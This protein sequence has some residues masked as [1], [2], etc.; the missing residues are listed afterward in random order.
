MEASAPLANEANSDA[1]DIDEKLQNVPVT[2]KSVLNVREQANLLKAFKSMRDIAVKRTFP[3]PFNGCEFSFDLSHPENASTHIARQHVS[4]KCIWCDE[5]HFEWWNEAQRQRHLRYKHR[6]K[7]LQTLGV[8]DPKIL[9]SSSDET[10]VI[11]L[12]QHECLAGEV[13]PDFGTDAPAPCRVEIFCDS[14]GRDNRNFTSIYEKEYHERTCQGQILGTKGQTFCADCGD[15]NVDGQQGQNRVCGHDPNRAIGQFCILCGID[16]S[17][18]GQFADLHRSSCRGHGSATRPFA[19]CCGRRLCSDD[20]TSDRQALIGA[21]RGNCNPT[22]KIEVVAKSQGQTPLTGTVPSPIAPSPASSEDYHPDAESSDSEPE[23]GRSRERQKKAVSKK[24]NKANKVPDRR[25]ASPDWSHVLGE[26]DPSFVPDNSYYCSK[27]LRR[28]P[29]ANRRRNGRKAVEIGEEYKVKQSQTLA[30]S[31]ANVFQYHIAGDRCCRI[32]S[33]IGSAE[34]LPNC[35]GWIPAN[36]ISKLGALKSQFLEKYPDYKATLY[37]L[38]ESD[39]RNNMW[40]SDPNNESNSANWNLPWP[41]Y[42]KHLPSLH[43]NVDSPAQDDGYASE[44]MFVPEKSNRG[45]GTGGRKRRRNSDGG[46]SYDSDTGSENGWSTNDDE[47]NPNRRRRR[48]LADGTYRPRKGDESDSD[49]E[50]ERLRKV[51]EEI[52]QEIESL[53]G[54]PVDG[55]GTAASPTKETSDPFIVHDD[56]H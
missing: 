9:S 51:R 29:K 18:L 44:A 27:C 46:Y 6:D 41:P 32:R 45:P 8:T 3:C 15:Y 16:T 2:S 26:P 52:V 55:S 14:C 7:L 37:P 19:P 23:R 43:E 48:R 47:S 54:P 22:S 10:V 40:R 34:N 31:N 20:D 33:G 53:R 50:P 17:L 56:A 38:R 1:M 35:S 39:A 11:A 21:H 12:T 4:K 5:T 30:A 24:N 28:V 42:M 49:N 36:K 13:A 25:P